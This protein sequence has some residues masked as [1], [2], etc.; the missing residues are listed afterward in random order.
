VRGCE[1]GGVGRL[2]QSARE[3][4]V[5]CGVDGTG[6]AGG[7]LDVDRHT[8]LAERLIHAVED[9]GHDDLLRAIDAELEVGALPDEQDMRVGNQTWQVQREPVAGLDL[10][11]ARRRTS[12]AFANRGSARS[13]RP[14][15]TSR[16]ARLLRVFRASGPCESPVASQTPRADRNIGMASSLRP[17]AAS[18]TPRSL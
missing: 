15:R 5:A 9:E 16:A 11:D 3:G 6:T 7:A 12:T 4:G 1:L 18:M 8:G 13:G 17:A 10:D 2:V 14:D